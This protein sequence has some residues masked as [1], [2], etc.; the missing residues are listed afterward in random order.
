MPIEEL[1]EFMMDHQIIFD[2]ALSTLRKQLNKPIGY[3]LLPEKFTMPELQNCMKSS[4]KKLKRGN[5]IEN[6][7]V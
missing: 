1:T 4:K 5:F 7:S 3:N 2:K 6:A